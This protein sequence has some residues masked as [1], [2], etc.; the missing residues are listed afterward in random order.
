MKTDSNKIYYT[1]SSH[2]EKKALPVT[3]LLSRKEEDAPS[4]GAETPLED[5][6]RDG[7]EASVAQRIADR[8]SADKL[9]IK[10][11]LS[12]RVGRLAS[13]KSSRPPQNVPMPPPVLPDTVKTKLPEIFRWPV[14]EDGELDDTKIPGSPGQ[15]TTSSFRSNGKTS[16]VKG[17]LLFT[18]LKDAHEQLNSYLRRH[19]D[20]LDVFTNTK[21]STQEEVYQL[22]K[23]I[24]NRGQ[25][26]REAI[27][28]LLEPLLD[29]AEQLLH[30]FTPPYIEKEHLVGIFWGSLA[31]I[32]RSAVST[33]ST[34]YIIPLNL[35]LKWTHCSEH[36]S[37]VLNN[38]SDTIYRKLTPTET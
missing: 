38:V 4:Q 21:K 27:A 11:N 34:N 35:P 10:A 6:E 29:A 14:G 37:Q 12:K 16:T 19:S 9:K 31:N 36:N 8:L 17:E 22:K 13:G 30:S 1:P 5:V 28:D 32:I 20:D 18:V 3:N 25:G 2:Q 23:E 33:L 24:D 7:E 15:Q 26:S